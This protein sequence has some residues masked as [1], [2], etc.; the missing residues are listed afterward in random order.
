MTG[1]HKTT[2]RRT[3]QDKKLK[4][5]I[6][7]ANFEKIEKK[8]AIVQKRKRT[9]L[10]DVDFIKACIKKL[11]FRIKQKK[12]HLKDYEG[13]EILIATEVVDY[14]EYQRQA[15]KGYYASETN[16]LV[17]VT[18]TKSGWCITGISRTYPTY[19]F[20]P[21]VTPQYCGNI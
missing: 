17:K 1:N 6:K 13:R 15:R 12:K 10:A 3:K 20:L 4:I 16:T 11:E 7:E 19:S 5:I 21:V 2:I 14:Q 8:L 18:R 9:N